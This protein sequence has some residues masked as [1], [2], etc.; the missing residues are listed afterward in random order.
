M[1]NEKTLQIF[2]FF[3]LR[4]GNIKKPD[5]VRHCQRQIQ[6]PENHK[7]LIMSRLDE[8]PIIRDDDFNKKIKNFDYFSRLSFFIR[9]ISHFGSE[10]GHSSKGG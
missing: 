4:R 6:V 1:N 8:P 10:N 9:K 3:I 5:Y 2:S 7:I